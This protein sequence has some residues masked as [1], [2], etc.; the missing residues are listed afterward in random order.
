MANPSGYPR[1]V[2]VMF[3]NGTGVI[4]YRENASSYLMD[5][6]FAWD[7]NYPKKVMLAIDNADPTAAVNLL[8]ASCAQWSVGTAALKLGDKVRLGLYQSDDITVDVQ[9][10]GVITD[11]HPTGEGVIIVEAYDP[12]KRLD[13][14][15]PSI[16]H[17]AN[18]RDQ[19]RHGY[20]D[21]VNYRALTFVT[22]TDLVEPLVS[23]E[24]AHTDDRD[25][26]G[27]TVLGTTHTLNADDEYAAQPFIAKGNLM[28]VHWNCTVAGGY[29]GDIEVELCMDA[30]TVPGT[31]LDSKTYLV[32]AGACTT[33]FTLARDAVELVKGRKY[34]VKFK[35]VDRTAGDITIRAEG[36]DSTDVFP[37][38]VYD[39]GGGAT[40]ET[41]DVLALDLDFLVY[42]EID[43]NLA[44][45]NDA[46]NLIGFWDG[47]PI[48]EIGGTAYAP[49][50]GRVSY[51][52]GTVTLEAL[53]QRLIKM[54]TGL[55]HDVDTDVDRTLKVYSTKGKSLGDCMRELMDLFE[56][57]GAWD[58]HQH[59]M[60][61]YVDVSDINRCRVGKRK[62]TSDSATYIL[63]HGKDTAN[64]DEHIIIGNPSLK[65]TNRRKYAS[66]TV[67]GKAP[68][69]EPLVCKRHDKALSTS[70]YNQMD[71]VVEHLNITDDNLR[72]LED[73]D[74]ECW[75]LLDAVQRD[76]WEGSIILS[77]QHE[78]VM[79]WNP[80]NETYGSGNIVTVNWSPLGISAVAMK[81][82]GMVLGP[83][84]TEIYVNNVDTL[85]KNRLTEGWGRSERSESF[86]APMGFVD[87]IFLEVNT[88]TVITDAVLYM[89]VHD[90]GGA[91]TWDRILCTKFTNSDYNT[92]VY[93]A[94]VPSGFSVGM[95][96]IEH[97]RL[98][99]AATGGTQRVTID[100]NQ[101]V[102]SIVTDVRPDKF[103]STKLI[104][105][106]SCPSS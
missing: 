78:D 6:E 91:V 64:D 26:Y 46:S 28:A 32:P 98:Y 86:Y 60:A 93:H 48:T 65:R 17:G 79:D 24:F 16:T 20:A 45:F 57:S 43:T 54:D 87:N 106:V 75:R 77:G 80:A 21:G 69:D 37:D 4:M 95:Q 2:H 70:F 61:H 25:N 22:D 66:V 10:N 19:A 88:T 51:Y 99:T 89:E 34:W 67:V 55:L 97:V 90:S 14:E 9:F 44:T 94:E 103:K 5:Y 82:T 58:G 36:P 39:S 50:R 68:N 23:L 85:L 96:G 15:K 35:V 1:E 49:L 47:V 8:N 11:I 3:D 52:Y 33:D 73:V 71:G 31:V 40:T 30:G 53:C 18:F 92:N 100:L 76:V 62:K 84:T 101:T 74:R 105:E 12:S 83:L 13:H 63:S 56:T 29:D 104:I 27:D 81:V 72:S 38:Y 7:E 42:D 102:S 59:V 41:N